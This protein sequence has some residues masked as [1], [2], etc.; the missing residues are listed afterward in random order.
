MRRQEPGGI[1]VAGAGRVHHLHWRRRNL[2]PLRAAQQHAAPLAPG[3]RSQPHL[4]RR[5]AG[6]ILEGVLLIQAAHLRLVGEQDVDLAAHQLAERCPVTVHAER[7]GQGQRDPASGGMGSIGGEA[8]RGLG[9]RRVEQVTLQQEHGGGGHQRRVHVRL[10][11]RD[12]GAQVGVHGA[13]PVG[14]DQDQAAR[15][16]RP[17]PQRR[18]REMHPGGGDVVA[19]HPAE[20]VV[21]NL[22]QVGHARA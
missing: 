16:G 6:C 11:E 20:L 10:A 21:G 5:E 22:A 3:Q 19:E 4:G 1:R 18:A 12:A 2:D 7:V 9:R 15:G 13:L 14:R 17:A 8:E